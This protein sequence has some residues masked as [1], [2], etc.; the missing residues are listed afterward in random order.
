M[1]TNKD[2]S[3][4]ISLLEDL[5]DRGSVD[6]QKEKALGNAIDELKRI[7]R[8]PNLQRHELSKSIRKIVEELF[9]AFTS[10]D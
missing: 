1:R 3:S 8:K 9:R 5:Q 2:L 10:R 6:P 4:C 7:R